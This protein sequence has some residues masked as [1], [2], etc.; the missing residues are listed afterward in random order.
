MV[1]P[2]FK[3]F[4]LNICLAE[5][6]TPACANVRQLANGNVFTNR[7]HPPFYFVLVVVNSRG[8]VAN[9]CLWKNKQFVSC[10]NVKTVTLTHQVLIITRL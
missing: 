6:G 2:P 10:L 8:S 9:I 3:K 5:D 7:R 1:T 4:L